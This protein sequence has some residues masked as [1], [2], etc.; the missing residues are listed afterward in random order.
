M[1]KSIR[2]NVTFEVKA[3][4]VPANDPERWP[5]LGGVIFYG[6]FGVDGRH[7]M[8]MPL[9]VWYKGE[10]RTHQRIEDVE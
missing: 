7:D 6:V 2:R 5:G 10:W 4:L 3:R 8:H 1:I 9:L